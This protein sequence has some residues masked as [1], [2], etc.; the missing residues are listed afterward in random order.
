M[1]RL[2][3]RLSGSFQD[4]AAGTLGGRAQLN[5]TPLAPVPAA[6][7][8]CGRRSTSLTAAQRAR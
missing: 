4:K 1:V 5:K 3:D 2:S 8:T 6:P 7:R